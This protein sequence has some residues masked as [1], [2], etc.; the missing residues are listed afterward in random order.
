MAL[1]RTG[2]SSRYWE[3]PEGYLSGPGM[4]AS[5]SY[6]LAGKG[7]VAEGADIMACDVIGTTLSVR[8][9]QTLG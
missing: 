3:D 2:N 1:I 9:I 8:R 5:A 6:W 7:I 4:A